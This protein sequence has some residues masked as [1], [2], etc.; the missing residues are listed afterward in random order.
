M[1]SLTTLPVTGYEIQSDS[2]A[3]PEQF[4]CNA[5]D[6]ADSRLNELREQFPK[7]TFSLVALIDA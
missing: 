7:I 4:G 1:Y 5:F 6:H 2:A 3:E